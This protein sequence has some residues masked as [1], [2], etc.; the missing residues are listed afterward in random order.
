MASTEFSST[1]SDAAVPPAAPRKRA[2]RNARRRRGKQ[3][4]KA[5]E[6]EQN[7][8]QSSTSSE[9]SSSARRRLRRKNQAGAPAAAPITPVPVGPVS[10]IPHNPKIPPASQA[11]LVAL[12]IRTSGLHPSSSRIV[13][14]SA[15]FLDASGQP[16]GY[17][18]RVVGGQEDVGPI[19]MHGFAHQQVAGAQG[20]EF[21]LRQ[22][23]RVLDHRVVF[24]HDTPSVW[25]FISHESRTSLHAA[26]N[27]RQRD[28]NR[29]RKVGRRPHVPRPLFL[30][31]T[32]ASARRQ[33]APITDPRI[34][35]VA[36]TYGLLDVTPAP[37]LFPPNDRVFSPALCAPRL[38]AEGYSALR[39]VGPAARTTELDIPPMDI[40]MADS[41]LTAEIGVEQVRQAGF[42]L[43]EVCQ[44]ASEMAQSA[45]SRP[46]R[47]RRGGYQPPQVDHLFEDARFR[48]LDVRFPHALKP[49]VHGFA[50][51]SARVEAVEAAPLAP[52]PGVWAPGSPLSP[53]MVVAVAAEVCADPD[54]LIA[55]A[56][57][58]GLTYSEKL[59]RETSLV[60][61]DGTGQGATAD[62]VPREGKAM[63][64]ARKG[65][66]LISS[67]EFFRAAGWA[68]LEEE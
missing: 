57:A 68:G 49:D 42:D 31:D 38:E 23:P 46:P 61:F 33:R 1:D 13:A 37:R 19:Q 55:A 48:A 27:A 9:L 16:V 30:I 58:A 26:I 25:G 43:A 15:V 65:I 41:V 50:Y 47:G 63:H 22:L 2:S 64:A 44:V 56:V 3:L 29:G 62:R 45:R 28:I 17:W 21:V 6:A 18:N 20:F 4:R 10:S 35:G 51:S 54:D 8:G 59:V 60:V 7:S 67:D 12:S 39:H 34:R 11:P 52:N 5:Q 66:P 24:V 36:H 40:L 53:G 32:L 14:L